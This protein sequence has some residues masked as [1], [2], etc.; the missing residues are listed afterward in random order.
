LAAAG[1]EHARKFD[2]SEVVSQYEAI[3]RRALDPSARHESV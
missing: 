2:W 3:Y 1:Q